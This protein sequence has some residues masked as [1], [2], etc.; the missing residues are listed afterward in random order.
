MAISYF[1]TKMIMF[2]AKAPIFITPDYGDITTQP[3]QGRWA[4]PMSS[5]CILL[6]L[7]FALIS[8]NLY[9]HN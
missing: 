7:C 5:L 1:Y 9:L 6:C 2:G 4:R 3:K 8:N